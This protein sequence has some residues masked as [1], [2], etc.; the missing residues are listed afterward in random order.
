MV[1][2]STLHGWY[3]RQDGQVFGP[4]STG[5][6]QELLAAGRLPARQV[7]WNRRDQRLLFVYAEAACDTACQSKAR[8]S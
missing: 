4:L 3:Y 1:S 5:Q 6:L 2:E 7:V 8:A